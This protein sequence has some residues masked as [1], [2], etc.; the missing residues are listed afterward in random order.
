[1]TNTDLKQLLESLPGIDNPVVIV[2]GDRPHLFA[3]VTSGSFSGMDEADRQDLV[4]GHF[5]DQRPPEDRLDVEFIF[6]NAPGEEESI[7]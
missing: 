4:W 2:H 3:T 6:T 1:M 7:A 5:R